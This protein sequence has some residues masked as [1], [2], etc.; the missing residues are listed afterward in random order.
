MDY[1]MLQ[2]LKDL[3]GPR[4]SETTAN[5]SSGPSSD[6]MEMKL[7]VIDAFVVV[8]QAKRKI[9]EELSSAVQKHGLDRTPM[10]PKMDPNVAFVILVEE[11]GEVA[12]ALTYDN[13]DPEA[14]ASELI[15]VAAM[16]TAMWVGL[17]LRSST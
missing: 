10:N 11:V 13:G 8:S 17:R 15:Q 1:E 5:E 9:T 3:V 14:L 2:Y 12:R 6:P 7:S 4:P 16:A